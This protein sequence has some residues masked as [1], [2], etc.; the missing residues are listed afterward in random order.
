[1]MYVGDEPWH[2]LGTKLDEPATAREAIIAA[3]LDWHVVKKPLYAGDEGKRKR[4]VPNRFAVV[5][6]HR[7]GR[8]DCPV[9]GIVGSEYTPLQNHEAFEFFDSIVGDKAAIYHTAGALGDGERIWILAKLPSDIEVAGDDVASKYSLFSNTHDGNNSVQIKFTPVRVV[10]QNTLT[11]ALGRGP[12]VRVVHTR[13]VRERLRQSEKLLG[14][15]NSRFSRI[16][17][18]FKKT[19]QFK[20]NESKLSGFLNRVFPDP[21]KQEGRD[22]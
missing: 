14:V 15:V 8:K 10:C 21:Q 20:M 6:E 13:D 4:R 16:E 12:T 11:M 5:P 1:M 18:V 3:R 17:E 9:F 22:S 19:A 2:G 7:W